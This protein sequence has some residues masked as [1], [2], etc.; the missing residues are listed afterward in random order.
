MEVTYTYGRTFKLLNHHNPSSFSVF[1]HICNCYLLLF[2]RLNS[3]RIRCKRKIY[4]LQFQCATSNLYKLKSMGG[5]TRSHSQKIKTPA[6]HRRSRR[7]Q[8]KTNGADLGVVL[9]IY[10]NSKFQI[11]NPNPYNVNKSNVFPTNINPSNS[12]PH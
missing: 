2:L 9:N 12:R 3:I 5:Y 6:H 7:S 8:G 11:P 4:T 1:L 10:P